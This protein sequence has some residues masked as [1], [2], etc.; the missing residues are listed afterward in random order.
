MI[1]QGDVKGLPP[2]GT[3]TNAPVGGVSGFRCKGSFQSIIPYCTV[4]HCRLDASDEKA[5]TQK[6]TPL[7]HRWSKVV[8]TAHKTRVGPIPETA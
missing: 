5:R 8:S 4:F 2:Q 3:W 1:K 7:A 6:K